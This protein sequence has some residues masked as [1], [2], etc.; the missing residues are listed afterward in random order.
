[1]QK[2]IGAA[3]LLAAGC[4]ISAAWDAT[5]RYEMGLLLGLAAVCTVV[6]RAI[7]ANAYELED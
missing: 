4:C 2:F 6:G 5:T 1:M 3:S 7:Y